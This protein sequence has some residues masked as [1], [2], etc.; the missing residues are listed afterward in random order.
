MV[1][2]RQSYALKHNFSRNAPM[3]EL[4]VTDLDERI[5]L[6]HHKSRCSEMDSRLV[7]NICTEIK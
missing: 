7:G 4:Q 1:S 6:R 3:G 5:G 2:E